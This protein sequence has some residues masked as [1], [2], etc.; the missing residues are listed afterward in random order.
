MDQLK[1]YADDR[2]I[3]GCIYCAGPPD[4]RDHVPSRCLLEPPYPPNLPVVGCCESC[5]R[6][7][8][9]DEE[10]FV[11]LIESVLCGSTDPDK[12]GRSSVARIMRNSAALRTRIEASRT[13]VDGQ[14]AFVPESE[15]IYNVMLKLARGH[16]AFELSQPC[17]NEPYH[18]WCGPL[19]SLTQENRLAFDS[20]H[21][22][23]IFGEVGSRNLQRMQVT[24][25]TFLSESGENQKVEILI[26]DWVEVQD[27]QYRYLAIDDAGEVVIRIVVAEYLACEIAWQL[28]VV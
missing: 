10:Y 26:N 17:R 4:T 14:I 18:F 19:A 5:N 27:D 21:F 24:Q 20:V 25:M 11:C 6:G 9:M 8:S 15:R 1:N 23:Q 13:E 2:L 28:Y 22:P 12:I 16:A 3:R 7:F